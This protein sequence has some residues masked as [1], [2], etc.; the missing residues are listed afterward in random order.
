M[1]SRARTNTLERVSVVCRTPS[2]PT[3]GFV[4]LHLTS[5]GRAT[6][7]GTPFFYFQPINTG[8]SGSGGTGTGTGGTGTGTGFG[9]PPPP[10]YP[11]GTFLASTLPTVGPMA[12]GTIVSISTSGLLNTP[13]LSCRFGTSIVLA[14]FISTV[15]LECVTPSRSPGSVAVEISLNGAQFDPVPPGLTFEYQG[16]VV[17]AGLTPYRGN[18]TASDCHTEGTNLGLQT[19]APVC[20]WSHKCWDI[21]PHPDSLSNASHTPG[22]LWWRSATIFRLLSSGSLFQFQLISVAS[23]S[24][25]H[26][27][28]WWRRNVA[29]GTNFL[30]PNEAIL[31][32]VFGSAPP[33]LAAWSPAPS[34]V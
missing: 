14:R 25:V 21:F 3:T 19:G 27:P 11:P 18:V 30:L 34:W 28:T 8:S 7:S 5:Y 23:E 26:V 24:R 31:W 32:C 10:P 22:L 29:V 4:N 12:G 13:D 1:A 2:S 9:P 20:A 33:V 16:E 17:V 6:E 15:L